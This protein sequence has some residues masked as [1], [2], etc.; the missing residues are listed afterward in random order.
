MRILI[1]GTKAH[2]LFVS[3]T[4][5]KFTSCRFV[6]NKKVFQIDIGNPFK[7]KKL[8]YLLITHTHYDHIEAFG[9]Q[10]EKALV[11]LPSLTFLRKLRSKSKLPFDF[12][13]IKGSSSINGLQIRPFIVY[14]SHTTLTYGF[15][16]KAKGLVW[17]W[18]PDYYRVP[19]F[20]GIISGVDC[21]FLGASAMKRDVKHKGLTGHRAVYKTLTEIS[22]MKKPPKRIVL[23][24]LGT[25][26]FPL[27]VKIPYLQRQFPKL[28]I[29]GTRDNQ[30]I[31]I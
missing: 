4:V 25:A 1:I 24:H 27:G 8:D 23:V 14:H 26:V 15:K 11:I 12:K 2:T 6:F 9:S 18:L 30:I 20:K 17:V 13:L 7:G 5:K 28:K 29:E 19:D 22:K 3:R 16:F 21:L 10:P 31:I